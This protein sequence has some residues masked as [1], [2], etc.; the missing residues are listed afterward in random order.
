[1]SSPGTVAP[2]M[3]ARVAQ[4][5]AAIM[6]AFAALVGFLTWWQVVDA[7][8]LRTKSYNNQT[9]WYEQRVQRG[10]IRS[11]DGVVLA[12]NRKRVAGNGDRVF[13]RTYPRGPLAAHVVGYSTTGKSRTGI[14]RTY[15]DSLTG[16]TRALGTWLDRLK[17]NEVVRG[18]SLQLSLVARAQAVAMGELGGQRGSVVALDPRTGAVLVLASSPSYDPNLVEGSFGKV[19]GAAGAPL[20]DRATQGRYAPGS[21][22]KVVTAAAALETGVDV[23]EDFPGGCSVDVPGAQDVRNFGGEC[24]GA[25]DF[26]YALTHSVNTSFAQ[27]GLDVGATK[28]REQMQRFGFDA[29]PALDDLPLGERFASGLYGPDGR[30]LGADEG[31]DVARVAI[32]QERLQVTPLQMAMVVAAV[33]NDG[34]PMRPYVVE[35]VVSPEGAVVSK[36]RRLPLDRAM[37]VANAQALRD[38]MKRVVREGTGTAAALEGIDVAG[39]TGTADMPSGNQVWFVAFAPADRPRVAIAVTVEGLPSGAT[40]GVVAA[41]IARAVMESLLGGQS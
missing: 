20:L 27:L 4:V 31:V 35:R 23:D 34:V 7:G 19:S 26:E 17:G 15:N 8:D 40:G 29:K 14:E 24:F 10:L 1:M 41:P 32:G 18:D 6:V 16:S 36:A 30:L 12:R 11:A 22:F 39:K 37:S 28:L 2:S 33:A 3:N 38:M 13:L 9:A 25:H 5:F 21:T